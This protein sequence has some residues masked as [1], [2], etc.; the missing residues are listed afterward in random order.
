MK[1][2]KTLHG[3][4]TLPTFFP[5]G[6]KAVVKGVDSTDLVN[7]GVEGLVI[8][9]YH[10]LVNSLGEKMEKFGGVHNFMNWPN[11][12]IT[13][14]GGFQVMSL[15]HDHPGMGKI[16]DNGITF[17]WDPSTSSTPLTTSSLRISGQ[18]VVL[19]PEKSI[20]LQ[21]KLDTDIAIVLD[22]CTRPDQASKDQEKSVERTIAWAKRSKDE[23]EKLVK[24]KRPLLFAVVQGGNNKKLRKKCAEALIEI[25]FDGYCYGGFPVD[26]KGK[27][28]TG[29]LEYVAKLLPDDK[30]KYALGIGRPENIIACAKMGYGIFDCVIPTREARHGKLYIWKGKSHG[31][32][33]IKSGKFAADSNPISQLCDCLTCK[34]YSRGYIHHLFKIGDTLSV[35][36]A[37]IHNLRFYSQ[38]MERLK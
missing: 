16:D 30:P 22:D 10:L 4:I 11:P 37:T 26:N 27:F 21:L 32:I 23:F 19:T 31:S 5:D 29:I 1:T 18:K 7:A 35:R 13:D 8:N 36:L 9:T 33:Y 20:E 34:N 14:S 28:M 38:L 24:T 15:V 12:V 17:K 6:T 3:K 2:L 25:G